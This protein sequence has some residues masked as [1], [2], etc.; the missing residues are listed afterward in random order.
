MLE[1]MDT[2][3]PRCSSNRSQGNRDRH[4]ARRSG[5]TAGPALGL[6]VEFF[7]GEGDGDLKV[8]IRFFDFGST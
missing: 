3:S 1:P 7:L 2:N 4:F 6:P 5:L 8:K